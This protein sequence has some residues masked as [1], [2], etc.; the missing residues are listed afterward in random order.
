LFTGEWEVIVG[1]NERTHM[2]SSAEAELIRQIE[3]LIQ[4]LAMG[5]ATP[6]DIQLLQDLQKARV[7]LMWP[8]MISQQDAQQEKLAQ[9]A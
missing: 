4:K 1:A 7:N 2:S 6:A 3:A 9:V 5:K 8:K